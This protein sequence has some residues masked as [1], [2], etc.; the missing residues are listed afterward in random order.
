MEALPLLFRKK[1]TSK[2]LPLLLNK[3]REDKKTP[4]SEFSYGILTGAHIEGSGVDFE[5][6]LWPL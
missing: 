1:R 4:T 5:Q 3:Y 2:A 6:I